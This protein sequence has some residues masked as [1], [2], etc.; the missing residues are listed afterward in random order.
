MNFLNPLMLSG[1]AALS[2]PVVI[3]FLNRFRVKTTDWGA[4][5]FLM[6]SV[7]QNQRRVN[8]Q[9]LLLLLLR[10][11]LVALAVL[12]F[13]R[14][15]QKALA[16][17][18]RESKGPIA[19]VV[20]LDNSASMGR[21]LGA[22]VCFDR[23]KRTITTWADA[24]DSQS[25]V[26]LCLVS[27]RAEPLI[28]KPGP[29]LG[30]FR[31]VLGEAE[32][33]DRGSDLLPGLRLAVE[34]LKNITGMPREIRIYTD[35]QGA[36]WL[37]SGEIL[38]LATDHPE[39]RFIPVVVADKLTDNLGIVSVRAESGTVAA[40]QPARFQVE[41]ANHGDKAVENVRVALSLEN[42]RSA[43]DATIAHLDPGATAS[44]V[45]TTSF[46]EAGPASVT[47]SIPADA[48][49]ADNHRS[50][51]LEVVSQTNVLICEEDPAAPPIDRDGFY[52]ANAVIPLSPDQAVRHF[53]AVTFVK[54]SD[55]AA[56]L[57]NSSNAAVQAVFLCNPAA[58]ST[59]DA[60]ALRDYVRTGGSLVIFPGPRTLV[61]EWKKNEILSDLLPATL[62]E[63][64]PDNE[65]TQSLTW[66]SGTFNHPV[67]ELWNDPA[68]GRLSAVKVFRHF[69]LT[70]KP[71]RRV[72]AALSDG[73]PVAVEGK[74]GE[75]SV[76][77]FA[78][79]ATPDLSNLPLHP[80]FVP[81][82]QRLMSY[83]N[84]KND[85]GLALSPGEAFRRTVPSE[86][87][88]EDFSVQR[89]DSDAAHSAGQVAADDGQ[90][91]V[92]YA[93]T[94]KA[95]VYHVRVGPDPLATFAVQL[96]PAESDLHPVD[97]S[98]FAALDAI[99]PAVTSGQSSQ[100][101]ITHE[102]WAALIWAAA[103]FFVLEALLAHRLS[104]A[105]A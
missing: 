9:D 43:G 2:V 105:R 5:R 60:G 99:K 85:A 88:G 54:P 16:G 63:P 95:G 38:K 1:L 29:D 14:P 76:V 66:Q 86:F 48:F 80:A 104:H 74:Y 17:L 25:L 13:A 19:A 4:M 39:I 37:K 23:A 75:G 11:L 42:N 36:A 64:T 40:Y 70:P 101:V 32:V 33:G 72:I 87:R 93:L 47:A 15:V 102:Y 6:E 55:L 78:T 96:D 34:S 31:K 89:P 30:L 12:A 8:L 28:P 81:L 90:T 22:E 92:R 41:V 91:Y 94:D 52:L 18:G 51:A 27:N 68:Q 61:P 79:P 44:A 7:R 49:A 67:T 65:E 84:R 46:A 20:L 10:L 58:P 35:G 73:A 77:L 50:V 71:D 82:T 100:M 69:P 83:V 59:A 3:H 21:S 53:M 98:V 62:G 57:T 24:L 26:G 103:A 45:I 97:P 56:E